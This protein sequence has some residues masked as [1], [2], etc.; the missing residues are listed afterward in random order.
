MLDHAA[1]SCNLQLLADYEM[2][3]AAALSRLQTEYKNK[4]EIL[5]FPAQVLT[6][7]RK[8]AKEVVEEEAAKTPIARKVHESFA[9]YQAKLSLWAGI[10]EGPYHRLIRI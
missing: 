2:K 10:S 5:Q 7:M 8:L 1:F 6:T 9:S 3:N 4:V